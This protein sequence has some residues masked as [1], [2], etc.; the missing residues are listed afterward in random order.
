MRERERNAL[1][2]VLA[3]DFASAVRGPILDAQ[4]AFYAQP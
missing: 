3:D 1:K 4:E 2:G